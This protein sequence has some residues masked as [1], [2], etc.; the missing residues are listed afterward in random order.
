M[1]FQYQYLPLLLSIVLFVHP[2]GLLGRQPLRSLRVGNQA[3]TNSESVVSGTSL[4]SVIVNGETRSY[5]IH[6]PSSKASVSRLPLVLNFH[7]LGSSAEDQEK[8]S[9]M[10]TLA[11]EC[12]FIVI[13]PEGRKNRRGAQH[14]A[15]RRTEDRSSELAFVRAILDNEKALNYD[16]KKVYATGIS[17][18]GG[19][20]NM[21]AGEMAETFAAIAPVAGAY[22]DY[23][24]FKPTRPVPVMS[25]HGTSDRI[26]PIQGRGDLPDIRQW[27]IWWAQ[28]NNCSPNSGVFF[29]QGE[30]MG[31]KWAGQADVILFTIE[32]K[33]HSWPGSLM[34]RMITTRQIN[35][36][37]LIWE[38]FQKYSIP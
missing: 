28:K 20:T 30:V 31:E 32:K 6:Q 1:I 35:A 26:V 3:N 15:T 23:Q 13:Y 19:M 16:F 12:G 11:D 22:Y 24:M 29:K 33:G 10:S 17:N 9:E 27:V 14:W 25:F 21:L 7:G 2:D 18:G 36:T 37:K 5:R 8:V 4:K 34:P 38:F